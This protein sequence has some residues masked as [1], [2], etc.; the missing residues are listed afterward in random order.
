MGRVDVID[1]VDVMARSSLCAD[2]LGRMRVANDAAPRM[3]CVSPYANLAGMAWTPH[4]T[5]FR[6]GNDVSLF[7]PRSLEVDVVL[8]KP[9]LYKGVWP[10]CVCDGLER[11]G[12]H[13]LDSLVESARC[14]SAVPSDI[15]RQLGE[16]SIS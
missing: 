13:F 16:L 15:R 7:L 2:A 10:R 1:A 14:R 12:I 6:R 11:I 5:S 9:L 8:S 4:S 3:Q